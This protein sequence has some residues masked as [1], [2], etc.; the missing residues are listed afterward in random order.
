M[1]EIFQKITDEIAPAL[2]AAMPTNCDG[3]LWTIKNHGICTLVRKPDENRD[4]LFGPVFPDSAIADYV[5]LD[6][7]YQVQFAF[8]VTELV[9]PSWASMG[10]AEKKRNEWSIRIIITSY[11]NL[12]TLGT[13]IRIALSELDHVTLDSIG[14]DTARNINAFQPNAPERGLDPLRCV[15]DTRIRYIHNANIN[16]EDLA[17]Y[18]N[19]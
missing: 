14:L 17:Q 9:T 18:E 6:D 15:L 1:I 8:V 13:R 5:T 19:Q 2:M 11:I 3:A 10:G 7:N 12:T 16:Y 4:Y